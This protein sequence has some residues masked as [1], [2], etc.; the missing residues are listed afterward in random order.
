VIYRVV[1]Y[2]RCQMNQLER[3]GDSHRAFLTLARDLAREQEQSGSKHF[4]A[5]REQVS[6]DLT[7]E[8]KIAR[9]DLDHRLGNL[10]ETVAN[11]CL[12]CLKAYAAPAGNAKDWRPAFTFHGSHL[13]AA[14]A[15]VLSLSPTSRKSMSIANTR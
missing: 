13:D 8:R 1:V 2:E 6:A 5:H 4:S 3:R 9:Y 11:R 7:H 10:V 15:I 14:L 12:N